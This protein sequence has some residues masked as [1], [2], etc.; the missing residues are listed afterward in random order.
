MADPRYYNQRLLS[1]LRDRS[2]Q[3]SGLRF[4]LKTSETS[5][6]ASWNVSLARSFS[7]LRE[8]SRSWMAWAKAPRSQT[9]SSC[10]NLSR[11]SSCWSSMRV[12]NFI[13]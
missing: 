2:W 10:V 13:Q 4:A 7:L 9:R 11:N 5:S 3:G 8:N 6:T 12:R 1:T